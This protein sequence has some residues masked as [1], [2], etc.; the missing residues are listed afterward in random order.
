[1]CVDALHLG[2]PFGGPAY[3]MLFLWV[4]VRYTLYVAHVSNVARF[5]SEPD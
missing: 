3:Q 4:V 1:M 5:V 2:L